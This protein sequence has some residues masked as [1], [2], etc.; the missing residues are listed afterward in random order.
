MNGDLLLVLVLLATCVILFVLNRPRMDVVALLAMIALPL[1]GVLSVN[2][3]L[4]GFSDPSVVLIAALFVI[5]DGLV[6][7]GIAYRLGAWLVRSA[8]SS[9]ARLLVLLMLAVAGLGSVMSSTGVVAIFIP[10]VLGIAARTQSAANRLMMPLAFAGLISGMLTLVATP[11]NLVVNSELRRAGLEGFG[12]FSFTPLGLAVLALGIVYMLLARRWLDRP[13]QQRAAAPRLSLAD[14]CDAYHLA[15]RERRL[16]VRPGSVLANR[17]LDGLE[18]R[19]QYGINVIAIERQHRFRR[20]LLMATG[21]TELLVGDVLLADIAS[22]AIGLLG[23]FDELGLEPLHLSNSYYRDHAQELGLAEVAL[24][25]DSRLPG[26]TIQELG[27]R[28]RH[29]LNVVGLRRQQR[30]LDG[31]L[32][33]EKL[34]A[35][36][37]LLVAGSW[38]H[39][40]RL[41][42]LSRDFLVLSLPAEVDDVAPAA[43]QAP[44]ALLAVAVMVGLMVSGTL[45]NVLCALIGCLLM[46]LFRCI[47]MDSAYKAIHW[48][49]LVLI[50]GMLPFALALQKTGGIAL[51]VD[52]LIGLFGDA[53]P[54]A[55]LACLFII[56]ALTGL[57][58]SNTATAVLMAPVAI[59]AAEHLGASPYPFAMTVALAA[60]AAFMTPI[61]SPVNTLVLN[62]GGYRFADFV[63]VGVPFTLLVL[64]LAVGLIPLLFPF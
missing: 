37:T 29:K 33:D 43:R 39:I 4:A 25:P 61:S 13:A 32:V 9:E 14:L 51:A 62:P 7:T 58:I 28:S 15:E 35:A 54:L 1:S 21:N 56:T 5:G 18:L 31:L 47:D 12:F 27:F 34:K 48:Q 60:S 44:F 24:P 6:R 49:S 38:K 26:K 22:P 20:L 36:D 63:R 40:H 42:G 55:L 11:P 8:G 46:G 59:S 23:A 52:G 41:Q 53:G 30:A 2:E 10:V 64:L 17:I 16:R 57:F 45:P 3:A 50:V 19:K